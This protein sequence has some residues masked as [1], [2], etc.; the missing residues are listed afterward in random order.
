M[1]ANQKGL[2]PIILIAIVIVL[3]IGAA[4]YFTG[5]TRNKNPNS[6]LTV[7]QNNSP[8]DQTPQ[9]SGQVKLIDQDLD[10]LSLLSKKDQKIN[11]FSAR[12]YQAGQF[13]S[14]KYQGY[15]RIIMVLQNWGQRG[16][17][18]YELITKDQKDYYFVYQ[19]GDFTQ[20]QVSDSRDPTYGLDQSKIK[21]K[22]NLSDSLPSVFPL[23]SQLGLY[24]HEI[25]V[26]GKDTGKLDDLKN[27]VFEYN[28]VTDLSG[29]TQ[30]KSPNPNL[31]IYFK[32]KL[33]DQYLKY[34]SEDQK[35]DFS[36]LSNYVEGST[37]VLV[38]DQTGLI[39]S[40]DQAYLAGIPIYEESVKNYEKSE[41]EN[42]IKQQEY[43]AKR[44]ELEKKGI[45]DTSSLG[46]YPFGNVPYPRRPSLRLDSK[47]LTSVYPL[48]NQYDVAIPQACATDVS[49]YLL[50]NISQDDLIE[51]GTFKGR[52]INS[53]KDKNHPLNKLAYKNKTDIP[54]GK[55]YDEFRKNLPDYN[56]YSSKYPHLIFQDYWD[57]WV[58]LGEWDLKLA[59]GGCGKPVIYLYPLKP[60]EV[61]ISFDKPV[62]FD[63]DIPK[64]N[65]G[66]NVLA[67]PDSTIT[68]LQPQS[69]DCNQ[70]NSEMFGSEYTK[71]ACLKNSY[72]Y[73]YW[74]GQSLG[75]DYPTI[76]DGW[77]VARDRLDSFLNE[78]LT[79]IGL[80]SKEKADMLSYWLVEMKN[81][82]APYYKI[83]F[84]Q[85]KDM[86]KIIPMTI[87]PKPDTLFRIFL[88]WLPLNKKPPFNIQPQ[89]L[90]K[91]NRTG[92]TVVE[93]G[94]L[95]R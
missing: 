93:W 58:L 45:T 91:V 57:R 23:N 47:Q 40:Y 86:N 87:Y 71:D 77:I 89:Y 38:T 60:T 49:T 6:S 21:G 25:Q 32:S 3:V 5:F 80:N 53:F 10:L 68:D 92:F 55:D 31:K 35:K 64:Y 33:D 11:G 51:V 19:N 8:A 39:A 27:P 15:T 9:I 14:G 7:S 72:P 12:Y 50:K 44:A 62:I 34:M 41:K 63:N 37:E 69:T 94:G 66:W 95:K 70:I 56:T 73:I 76:S 82:N 29:L 16:Y 59:I 43:D 18:V 22:I 52:K 26:Q 28:L 42:N 46:N 54:E 65:N 85:S 79:E 81:K 75:G 17:A 1:F 20:S 30:L 2:A 88:D 67:Y 36:I 4:L 83:S 13:T 84:L 90:D 61:S 48:F 74:S 24:R 78:K